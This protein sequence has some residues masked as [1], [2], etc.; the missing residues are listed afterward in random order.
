V[1][2]SVVILE[3]FCLK[4]NGGII[5]SSMEHHTHKKLYKSSTNKVIAGVC[6]GIA[7]YLEV[8]ATILRLLWVIFVLFTGIFPGVIIYLIAALIMPTKH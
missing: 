2:G 8:D 5:I 6:G 3:L 4:S 1:C 7:E